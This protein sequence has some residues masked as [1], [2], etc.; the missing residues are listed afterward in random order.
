MLDTSIDFYRRTAIHPPLLAQKV[1][2][3]GDSVANPVIEIK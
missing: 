2:N 1:P 3:C